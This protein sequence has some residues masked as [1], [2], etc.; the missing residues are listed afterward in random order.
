MWIGLKRL[1]MNRRLMVI[2]TAIAVVLFV[3]TGAPAENSSTTAPSDAPTVTQAQDA[4]DIP[5]LAPL[6]LFRRAG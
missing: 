3:R 5:P 6:D 4:S 2:T 1:M